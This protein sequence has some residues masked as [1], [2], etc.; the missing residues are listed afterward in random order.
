[1]KDFSEYKLFFQTSLN[2]RFTVDMLSSKEIK[3][4]LK[5]MFMSQRLANTKIAI[6]KNYFTLLE[7]TSK[8]QYSYLYFMQMY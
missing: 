2:S 1:M 5:K 7:Q 6:G 8:K 3:Q 4:L